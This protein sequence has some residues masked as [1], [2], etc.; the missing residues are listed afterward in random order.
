MDIL[1]VLRSDGA[2]PSVRKL[3]NHSQL[4]AF[5]YG[6][7]FARASVVRNGNTDLI[8]VS[9]T[10]AIDEHGVSLYQETS[11]HRSIAHSIRWRRF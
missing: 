4:D 3:S 7:A 11:G 5:R 2:E 6:S 9:G 8:Q 1:A 10:A